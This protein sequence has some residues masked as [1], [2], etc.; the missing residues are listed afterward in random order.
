[1]GM[2]HFRSAAGDD[3]LAA[4]GRNVRRI[5]T[6]QGITQSRL[7][8]MVNTSRSYLC[9]VEAGRRN[10]TMR[11]LARIAACLDVPPAE[12]LLMT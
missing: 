7:A 10:V 1:M 2:E 4:V 12:L 8:A 6:A 9:D 11:E 5:R 3:I